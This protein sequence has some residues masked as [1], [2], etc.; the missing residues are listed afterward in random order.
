MC[1]KFIMEASLNKVEII[2][3]CSN[4]SKLPSYGNILLQEY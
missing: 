4:S 1:F 2:E 3:R